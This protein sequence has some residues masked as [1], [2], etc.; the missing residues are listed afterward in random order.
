[1]LYNFVFRNNKNEAEKQTNSNTT[2]TANTST[3]STA[4]KEKKKTLDCG[5]QVNFTQ[6]DHLSGIANRKSHPNI[7]EPEVA[8]IFKK[9][10]SRNAEVDMDELERRLRKS[11]KEVGTFTEI[12]Y[13]IPWIFFFCAKCFGVGYHLNMCFPQGWVN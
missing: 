10:Y 1:M 13:N 12:L 6:F 5:K 7:P 8:M 4:K 9:S 3:T 11:K 2:T